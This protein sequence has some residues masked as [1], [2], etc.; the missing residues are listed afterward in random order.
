MTLFKS[1]YVGNAH[2][3]RSFSFIN[4]STSIMIMDDITMRKAGDKRKEE[5]RRRL[6]AMGLLAC[7]ALYF[8]WFAGSSALY[9]YDGRFIRVE[10][11]PPPGP[12]QPPP[13][14]FAVCGRTATFHRASWSLQQKYYNVTNCPPFDP[15]K[16]TLELNQK[17]IAGRT[18]N[19][20]RA[21]LR[22]VQ[23]VR[24]KHIQLSVTPDSWV[25]LGLINS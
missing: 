3:A 11:Q 13:E 1:R 16:K 8:S 25:S 22:A 4:F 15:K 14:A 23:Y 18:G 19:E 7:L 10:E 5:L 21:F 12:Q 24:D 9:Y 6:M 2:V 20:L 17:N